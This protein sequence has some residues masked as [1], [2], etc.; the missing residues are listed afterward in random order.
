LKLSGFSRS[1]TGGRG[2]GSGMG[3]GGLGPGPGW[4]PGVGLGIGGG[5]WDSG[6]KHANN[7]EDPLIF[8]IS[9]FQKRSGSRMSC[10]Y[11]MVETALDRE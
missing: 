5:E 10:T 6:V 3:P 1:M 11:C 7:R 8:I 2:T 9:S 4:G